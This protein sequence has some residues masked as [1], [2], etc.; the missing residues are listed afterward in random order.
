MF[1]GLNL[2]LGNYIGEFLGELCLGTFFPLSG[3]SLLAEA[4]FPLGLGWSGAAFGV[5]F[6]VGALRN[7]PM[8]RVRSPG[9]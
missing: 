6:L 3:L 7:A 1:L 4:R 9:R 8:P 5:V 2:C